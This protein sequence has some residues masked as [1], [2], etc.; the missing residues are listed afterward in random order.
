M[1][2]EN[3]GCSRDCGRRAVDE[4]VN[5]RCTAD[6]FQ[7]LPEIAA[8]R[9]TK[10]NRSSARIVPQTFSQRRQL[11]A[12]FLHTYGFKFRPGTPKTMGS[13]APTILGWSNRVY[14]VSWAFWNLQWLRRLTYQHHERIRAPERRRSPWCSVCF[15]LYCE[16]LALYLYAADATVSH[17]LTGQPDTAIKI[18]AYAVEVIP[19]HSFR[20][21]TRNK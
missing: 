1:P 16:H 11:T 4:D 9:M 7:W 20:E 6:E 14:S 17:V 12:R 21:R 15:M 3:P 2:D 13:M 18:M 10:P 19:L 8:N 5:G